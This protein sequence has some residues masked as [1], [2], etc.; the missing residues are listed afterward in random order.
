VSPSGESL[1]LDGVFHDSEAC[2][3]ALVGGDVFEEKLLLENDNTTEQ[4]AKRL[5]NLEMFNQIYVYAGK[6]E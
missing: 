1:I 4:V 3:A 2:V 6:E 5:K